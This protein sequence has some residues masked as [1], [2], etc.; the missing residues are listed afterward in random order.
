[1]KRLLLALNLL[2]IFAI[3][4]SAKGTISADSTINLAL[5]QKATNPALAEKYLRPLAT[6]ANPRAMMELGVLYVFT[7]Q[8]SAQ[9]AEGLKLLESAAKAGYTEANDYLGL[10][11]FQHKDYAKAKRYFDARP[12]DHQGFAYA[13]LGSMYLE[14]K[15]VRENGTKARENFHQAA[16]KGYS[17]GM[18]LYA[19]LLGTKNGGSLNYPDAF[20]WHYIAGELGENYSRVMLFRPMFPE[21]PATDEVGQKSQQ[22]LA[23]IEKVHTGMNLKTQPIYKNGFLPG[24]K[25]TEKAAEAGDDWA[26]FYLGS[27]NYNG[28]FL[29]QNL[30]RAKYYYE[31]IVKN[32]KLPKPVLTLVN[33]RLQKM[34][35]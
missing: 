31:P 33:E 29:N 30:A 28:D 18:S 12:N 11:Y 7:P 4:A 3:S 22:A 20:F 21:A 1:M 8:Y 13:A 9:S 10:Y 26:R 14:G 19:N 17:R 32:G 15:G 2:L 24:L 23:W 6:E 16:L 27:M 34:K 5:A 35:K 25:T